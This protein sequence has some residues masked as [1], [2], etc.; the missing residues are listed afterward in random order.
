MSHGIGMSSRYGEISDAVHRRRA[1][2]E[3]LGSDTLRRDG[4]YSFRSIRL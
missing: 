1:A 3:A 4:R 2:Q